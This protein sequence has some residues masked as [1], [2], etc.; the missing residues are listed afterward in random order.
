METRILLLENST[1][2][3]QESIGKSN[4]LYDSYSSSYY[5]Y[6]D[7]DNY[8]SDN[9]SDFVQ[10]CENDYV[11]SFGSIFTQVWYSLI[12]IFSLIG[13]ILVLWILMKYEKLRSLTD[14]FILN[15][16][17]SDLLFTCSLPFWAVDH[18]HGWIFGSAMCKIMSAI[19]FVGYY[20]GILLLTLMTVDRYFAVVHALPAMRIRGFRYG[21]VAC[22][23]VWCVS[24]LATVPEMIFSEVLVNAD[25]GFLCSSSYPEGS[26]L[27]WQQF[28]YYLQ[29]IL[30]FLIP[31]M[32]IVLSYYK[33]FNTV[34]KCRAK[35][36]QKTVKVIFCIVVVFLLCWAPYNI[37]IFLYSLHDLQVPSLSTCIASNNL[38][39][40]LFISRNIAYFHCCLNPF[41]YAFVGTKFRE[42]LNRV[43]S[44][45]FPYLNVCK[46]TNTS[47][48]KMNSSHNYSDFDLHLQDRV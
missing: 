22:S 44:K 2:L 21:V 33:I 20:S 23:V 47:S 38:S 19:F 24:I 27:I 31:F 5:Y 10:L 15:L 16:V 13:N 30:F 32:V 39:Y 8:S 6:N 12:F 42:R 35:K 45:R 25:Q 41:F 4:T 46:E 3:D 11:N 48:T 7:N 18:E 14:I 40:A 28:G 1:L 34:V 26:E 36:K 9:Y 43:A 29:N 17:T 37:V